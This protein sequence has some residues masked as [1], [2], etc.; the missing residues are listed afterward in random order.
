MRL[1]VS[2]IGKTL[3]ECVNLVLFRRV[4]VAEFE[5]RMLN[6]LRGGE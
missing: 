1:K 6:A 4:A 3:P 2:P 5:D